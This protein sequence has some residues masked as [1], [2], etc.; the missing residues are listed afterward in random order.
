MQSSIASLEPHRHTLSAV[1][2]GQK[3]QYLAQKDALITQSKDRV[4]EFAEHK[5]KFVKQLHGKENRPCEGQEDLS[6]M[7][8]QAIE[9]FGKD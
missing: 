8:E 7:N 2:H 6:V 4:K 5:S 3:S 1:F 9:H